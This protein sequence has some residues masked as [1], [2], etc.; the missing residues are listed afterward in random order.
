MN[1]MKRAL[2]LLL[3]MAATAF[4]GELKM[5]PFGESF[6]FSLGTCCY[7]FGLIWFRQLR[8]FETGV[9]VGFFLLFFRSLL[10]AAQHGGTF[11]Q[12]VPT[13]FPSTVY[14]LL[15]ASVLTLTDMR[16]RL[17]R[18]LLVGL[19]GTLGDLTGNVGELLTRNALGADYPL[20]LH[21][22]LIL[23]LFGAMRSFF[24]VGLY[25]MLMIRQVRALGLQQQKQI[26]RLLMI[27][28]SLYEEGFYLQKS[29]RHI[30]EITRNSYDLYKQ[31]MEQEKKGA[32]PASL[33]RRALFIAEEVHE[34]KKDTQRILAGLDK[35]IKQE[36]LTERMPLRQ[37]CEL[38]VSANRKYA[39]MLGKEID[40][41]L[42]TDI[43]LGTTR[44]YPLVSILNN[45][46]ANAVEAIRERGRIGLE[47][48]LKEGQ[49]EWQVWD[50]GPGISSEDAKYIYQPGYT[51]KY[52][53][54]GNPS[55]GI[56]L[57]HCQDLAA[58]LGG[59]LTLVQQN[60]IT[61]FVMCMPTSE[62]LEK[63]KGM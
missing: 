63:E 8:P 29:M 22:L 40:F 24:V 50:D 4:F 53:S 16:K 23:L 21:T 3:I 27:N 47:V 1:M 42:H 17:D 59:S 10:D 32:L 46:I 13:H 48:H 62:L 6:R 31:L 54:A 15:F 55:T 36:S 18:P 57:S 52:D 58:M 49:I 12:Y 51:T 41:I 20:G 60:G 38:V 14:Y 44:I 33:S 43:N 39:R 19:C 34:L 2:L 61:R 11:S 35:L 30:E 5:N 37:L 26:D 25:N 56:G 28:S 7:F 9:S 45:L